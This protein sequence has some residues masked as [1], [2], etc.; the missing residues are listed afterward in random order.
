MEILSV[1]IGKPDSAQ[2]AFALRLGQP[3]NDREYFSERRARKNQL[4]N[5]KYR[6]AGKETG[7][8][9]R[10]FDSG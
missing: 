7:L 2:H 8:V 1:L 3:S 6:L 9:L 10:P 4:E 5:P